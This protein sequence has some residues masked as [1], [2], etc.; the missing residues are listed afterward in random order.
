MSDFLQEA[1]AVAGQVR[2]ALGGGGGRGAAAGCK[3]GVLRDGRRGGKKRH[4]CRAPPKV[5]CIP[6]TQ[7]AALTPRG[8]I[9]P[10]GVCRSKQRKQEQQQEQGAA[11][12]Q[13][14]PSRSRPVG[15]QALHH[16]RRH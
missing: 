3:G 16:A 6:C 8:C 7:H 10:G 13:Q 4:A 5:V 2:T 14:P 11:A 9:A 1:A 12:R 15:P